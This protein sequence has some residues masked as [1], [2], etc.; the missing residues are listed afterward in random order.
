MIRYQVSY[1]VL[2]GEHPGA[3]VSEVRRPA[4]GDQVTI[5]QYTFEVVEVHEVMPMR[6]DFA[7]LHATVRPL[8]TIPHPEDERA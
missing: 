4:V 5:G 8:Q 6:G 7:F 3:I 1:V 2:G